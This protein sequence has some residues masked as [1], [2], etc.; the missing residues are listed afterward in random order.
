MTKPDHRSCPH[1]YKA[2][3]GSEEGTRNRRRSKCADCEE[4]IRKRI[5][6]QPG[7]RAA[8]IQ[9]QREHSVAPFYRRSKDE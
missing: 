4:I 5:Q 1:P 8:K 6:A 2:L 9:Q 7:V 3:C